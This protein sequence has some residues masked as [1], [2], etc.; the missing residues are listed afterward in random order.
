M[1]L[2]RTKLMLVIAVVFAIMAA[3]LANNWV[4]RRAAT[5]NDKT[6]E[7]KTVVVAKLE[8]ASG[9]KVEA[10]QLK[11]VEWPIELVPEGAVGKLEDAV[12]KIAKQPI[13]PGD[14]LTTGRIASDLGGSHLA[15]LISANMRAVSIRVDD[16][17]GVA[18]FLLPGNRVD[19]IGVVREEHTNRVHAST[20]LTDVPVLA[21]DQDIAPDETKA[22][23]VRAVTLEVA[24][25]DAEL[26][27]KAM[28][29]GKIQLS[30]RNPGE[31]QV[32]A[33][34]VKAEVVKPK[35]KPRPR[36]PAKVIEKNEVILI[37]G[38]EVTEVETKS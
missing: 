33:E 10:V 20:V 19:V 32:V 17:V 7:V 18:G 36:A 38:T 28:N 27:V 34:V 21:V 2:N 35:P 5:A 15:A 13:Q 6:V 3:W 12:G 23:I 37:R 14:V 31:R 1:T 9:Q 4:Q 25:A 16:V 26:L 30:L 29:E 8:I 24:P 22:K 11:T